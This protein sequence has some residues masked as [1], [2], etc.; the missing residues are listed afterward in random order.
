MR[1]LAWRGRVKWLAD[2]RGPTLYHVFPYGKPSFHGAFLGGHFSSLALW[3]K[4]KGDLWQY[5]Q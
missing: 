3:H 4:A 5:R 2:Q 1:K